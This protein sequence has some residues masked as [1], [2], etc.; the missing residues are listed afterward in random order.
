VIISLT[1]YTN[2]GICMTWLHHFI[3]HND[4]GP[5]K[6]WHILLIDSATCYKVLE[7][8]ITIKMNKIWVV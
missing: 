2:E 8:I 5:N 6:K 7:F 3:K 1:G 4:C